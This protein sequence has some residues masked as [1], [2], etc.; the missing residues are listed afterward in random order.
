MNQ[1]YN[2]VQQRGKH[3]VKDFFRMPAV[4][5]KFSEVLGDGANG[6]VTSLLNLASQD[7][8]LEEAEPN[9]VMQAA[10]VAATLK[11]PIEKNLGF[12]YVIPYKGVAQFQ[13]GYKGLIQLALRSGQVVRINSGEIYR[14]QFISFNPLTE[15]LRLDEMADI[16]DA[17]KPVGYF[18]YMKL[19]NGFEKTIYWPYAKIV[20][21]A[22]KYSR[23]FN[24]KSSPWQ[25]DFDAMAEKTLL[26]RLL[27]TYAPLSSEMQKAIIA[28]DQDSTVNERQDVTPNEN[29]ASAVK[30]IM[31]AS[32]N[33]E[34]D[35]HTDEHTEGGV[36][37]SNSVPEIKEWLDQ[38]GI[39]YQ[40][41]LRKTELLEVA[42]QNGN[43]F[44]PLVED[45]QEKS[46]ESEL[47]N[48][49]PKGYMGES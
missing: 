20:K 19:A 48:L 37:D 30:Q 12:A 15:E 8:N 32:S 1:Q 9:S 2:Q 36:T 47:N 46:D 34:V 4:S 44:K 7:K 27:G 22:K 39:E 26:K 40:T 17:D 5:K 23:S 16:E 43:S 11:L 41:G 14:E 38:H 3:A 13:I 33:N 25:S 45:K 24:S 21:H 42:Y 6:F 18:A 10:M 31:N 29:Q 28:D 49:F 35:N